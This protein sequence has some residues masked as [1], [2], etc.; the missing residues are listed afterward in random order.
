MQTETKAE[1]KAECTPGRARTETG[2]RRT[3]RYLPSSAGGCTPVRSTTV[4]ISTTRFVAPHPPPVP[5]IDS[6]MCHSRQKKVKRD[7]SPKSPWV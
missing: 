1:T 5:N 3:P 4:P 6:I 7:F 2:F